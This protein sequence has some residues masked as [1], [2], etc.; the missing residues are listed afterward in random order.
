M[1]NIRRIGAM[2]LDIKANV[3]VR[4]LVAPLLLL[5]AVLLAAGRL[6]Y[7]QG[8]SY[9]GSTFLL[10]AANYLALR[11]R[12]D[13]IQERL[14]PGKGTKSWDKLYFALSTPLFLA[15]IILAALDAGRYRWGPAVPPWAYLAGWGVYAAGQSLHLWA[16]AAN[17]WFATV[18][19]IQS[20]RGQTVCSSGPYRFVRH[21]GY[22]GGLLFMLATPLILGSWLALIPQALAAVLLVLRTSREDRTL[23]AELP[24]Y[25]DY[26]CRVRRRLCPL[27]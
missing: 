5:A 8:W 21:P 15:V 26:A 27:W 23:R 19:R 11:D 6:S 3:L 7:W 18:V 9:A 1:L 4:S 12:P 20:D 2:K 13:L 10:L 25:E 16:K 17:R 22:A 24:G 14:S